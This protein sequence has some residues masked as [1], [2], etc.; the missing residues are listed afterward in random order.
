MRYTSSSFRVDLPFW[1][2]PKGP[3]GQGAKSL[4]VMLST[5]ARPEPE[6][7]RGSPVNS[8]TSRNQTAGS[9]F[10]TAVEHGNQTDFEARGDKI[11]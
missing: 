2:D 1:L 10:P 11:H 8:R 9:G 5:P 7:I 4:S 6:R 3:K